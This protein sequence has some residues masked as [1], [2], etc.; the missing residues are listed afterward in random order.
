MRI[1]R[2]LD[3]LGRAAIARALGFEAEAALRPTSDPKHGDYQLNGILPLSKQLKQNPRALAENV[4]AELTPDLTDN[5]I[6]KAEVAGPG[7]INLHLSE[8]WL[9]RALDEQARDHARDGVPVAERSERVVVDFSGPNIAKQMHV[10]HLRSTIIG[11]ALIKLLRFIGHDVIGDNHLGDW[12]TQFGLLIVGMREFG[13]AAALEQDPIVE[14]ERIYKQSSERAKTDAVFASA[15]RA[16]LAKLQSGDAENTALW[17]RFVDITK[18]ELNKVYDRLEVKFDT[19]YGES[20]YNPFLADTVARL[21]ERK[22]VTVDAGAKCI[23]FAELDVAPELKKQKEPLIVQKQ[24]GAFLYSTTDLATLRYRAEEQQAQRAIYVVDMRQALHFKQVFAVARLMGLD[25]LRAEHLGF[26]SVL[27]KDGKPLKTR[28]ASGK[29]ITLASLLDEA[30]QRALQ[31]L[32]EARAEGKLD[33]EDLAALARA[34]G[35]GAVKYA[36]LHQNRAS[37][38]QFDFDKMISFQ[39]NAGPYLQYAYARVRSIFRKGELAL[40]SAEGPIALEAREEKVLALTLVRFGDVVHQAAESG[41]PHLVTDHLY[42]LAKAYSAFFEACP[43]LKAEGP[44]RVSRLALC[45][46]TAR[47]LQRGL[48]LLGIQTVERM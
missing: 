12:G 39:G 26:G 31:R 13:D 15:A 36:D 43:V 16:E 27:G 45:A 23:F 40:E 4:A 48:G 20:F 5:A 11:D 3:G 46:L 33:V 22:L 44:E 6:A 17:Q 30:E 47:Q 9:A 7:F 28:D 34:V 19:W 14:L 8:A 41:L 10:G 38:Y 25:G 18:H 21:E 37:D 29:A 1:E 24:D 35:I 32:E 42:A 2:F